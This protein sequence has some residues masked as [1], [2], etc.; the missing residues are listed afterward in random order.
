M[1]DLRPGAVKTSQMATHFLEL[2]F[3]GSVEVVRHAL[4]LPLE[5]LL[6]LEGKQREG[7]HH[8]E[9]GY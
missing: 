5:A 8:R 2:C 7:Q 9:E 4:L 1:G 3:A 6:R